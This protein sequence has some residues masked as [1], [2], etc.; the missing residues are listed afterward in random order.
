MLDLVEARLRARY[1]GRREDTYRDGALRVAVNLEAHGPVCEVDR[2]F[3]GGPDGDACDADVLIERT[4]LEIRTLNAEVVGPRLS[5]TE[6]VAEIERLRARL[7]D[8]E[9][10]G[11][12]EGDRLDGWE[13]AM[14]NIA[15]NALAVDPTCSLCE[16]GHVP[17]VERRVEPGF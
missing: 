3:L 12:R 15:F 4:L 13:D 17:H 9:V 11:A 16:A 14:R 5:R 8:I 10:Y 1:P 7:R 6:L 2:M